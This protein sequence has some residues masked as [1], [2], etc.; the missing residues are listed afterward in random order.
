MAYSITANTITKFTF[1]KHI[2]K[3]IEEFEVWDYRHR[4]ETIDRLRNETYAS[5][6]TLIGSTNFKKLWTKQLNR[7][8]STSTIIYLVTRTNFT[9]QSRLWPQ[10]IG[11]KMRFEDFDSWKCTSILESQH[12]PLT[13]VIFD[14]LRLSAQI[15]NFVA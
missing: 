15:F 13:W 9:T 12:K 11:K 1:W 8:N 4:A 2:E 7:S 5:W 14:A 3:K 6:F 10:I